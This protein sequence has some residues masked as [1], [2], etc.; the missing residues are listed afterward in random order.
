MNLLRSLEGV[1]DVSSSSKSIICQPQGS[2]RSKATEATL[3]V[4]AQGMLCRC[5]GLLCSR[6]SPRRGLARLGK[7]FAR[8]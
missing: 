7:Q 4:M 2:H 8:A 3:H 1:R 6:L 5:L